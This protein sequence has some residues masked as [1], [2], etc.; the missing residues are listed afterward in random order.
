MVARCSCGPTAG[1]LLWPSSGT[2]RG[3]GW[4]QVAVAAAAARI[5]RI[6]GRSARAG[7]MPESLR[8]ELADR[9]GEGGER[10]RLDEVAAEPRRR[11]AVLILLL[12]IPREG[13]QPQRGAPEERPQLGRELVAVH[14]GQA[15]VE[16]GEVR[17]S[18]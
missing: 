1:A 10:D 8:H 11:G 5:S 16:D 12:A 4:L 14:D 13:D 7:A 9:P 2:R 3:A 17:R 18:S 15:D 6:E